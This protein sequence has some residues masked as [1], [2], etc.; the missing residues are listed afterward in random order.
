MQLRLICFQL[1]IFHFVC[2]FLMSV[3]IAGDLEIC[4]ENFDL[5]IVCRCDAQM[6]EIENCD[7]ADIVY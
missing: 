7:G 3:G 6:N 2:P 5:D 4:K 1:E